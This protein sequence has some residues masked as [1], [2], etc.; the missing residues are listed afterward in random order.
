LPR[1][2]Q[3]E[4]SFLPRVPVIVDP[5][6]YSAKEVD[7]LPRE[8][9]TIT[10]NYPD[11]ALRREVAGEV[12]L[13]LLLDESGGVQTA[14]VVDARPPGYFEQSALEAFRAGRFA[15]AYKDGRPVKSLVLIRVNYELK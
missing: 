8:L 9:A 5:N 4:P 6:Y 12:T 14:E 2:E 3:P 7:V 1:P 13:K 15:P 11:E 10:P